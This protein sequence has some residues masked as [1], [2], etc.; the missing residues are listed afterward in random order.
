MEYAAENVPRGPVTLADL[1]EEELDQASTSRLP[2]AL[3]HALHRKALSLGSDTYID[4]ET[5][6]MVF[7]RRR[8]AQLP[9]CG[10]RCRHCP[11]K[12]VN[13]PST[14]ADVEARWGWG[15][16]SARIFDW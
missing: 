15:A 5:G 13:V 6:L 12:H 16:I 8:L 3:A 11:H 9:C 10:N 2:L 14:A 7:T 4:P 1:S